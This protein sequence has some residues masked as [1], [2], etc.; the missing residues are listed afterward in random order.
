[1][2]SNKILLNKYAID[3]III[4][5]KNPEKQIKHI[6]FELKKKFKTN[7]KSYYFFKKFNLWHYKIREKV[8][9]HLKNHFFHNEEFD[10]NVFPHNEFY[11][12]YVVCQY[13]YFN[14]KIDYNFFYN[15]TLDDYKAIYNY[16][17]KIHDE[18]KANFNIEFLKYLNE[19]KNNN[20]LDQISK[21]LYELKYNPNT[22]N[23]QNYYIFFKSF[24]NALNQENIFEIEPYNSE[25]EI[26]IITAKKNEYF[27][28]SFSD[29]TEKKYVRIISPGW[30][31][32]N[33][34]IIN[35]KYQEVEEK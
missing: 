17:I 14:K 7:F 3:S 24:L 32:K 28:S 2:K 19:D 31:Y 29:S 12:L 23:Y 26:D 20:L 13:Y 9:T 22:I 34:K 15:L 27:G 10:F 30:K 5:F 8:F 18:L 25:K 4:L 33:K 35:V 11:I 21:N 16:Q 6:D 1:M